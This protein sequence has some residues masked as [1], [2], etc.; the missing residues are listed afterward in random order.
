MV[1]GRQLDELRA[2]VRAE[3]WGYPCVGLRVV[4]N[5]TIQRGDTLPPSYR[6]VDGEPT[7][8]LLDGTSAVDIKSRGSIPCDYRGTRVLVVG[9]TD[10]GSGEDVG[11]VLVEHAVVLAIYEFEDACN[12]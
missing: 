5:N 9:G 7:D 12:F 8:E 11:E 2:K 3:A 6:W 10:V 1:T 4:S